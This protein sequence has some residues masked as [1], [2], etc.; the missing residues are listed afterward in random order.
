MSWLRLGKIRLPPTIKWKLPVDKV[1]YLYVHI[2]Y[3]LLAVAVLGPHRTDRC[4]KRRFWLID[5]FGA[6]I[7]HARR[8]TM[9][10]HICLHHSDGYNMPKVNAD[11]ARDITVSHSKTSAGFCKI[12]K[13]VRRQKL[14]LVKT[15]RNSHRYKTYF[16]Y[17]ISKNRQLF[18][19]IFKYS[20]PTHLY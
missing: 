2:T 9:G 15:L 4:L 3:S 16:R 1:R 7:R 17:N 14:N 10:K 19:D 13:Y 18:G 8:W 12:R 6:V 20:Q 5:N 11:P